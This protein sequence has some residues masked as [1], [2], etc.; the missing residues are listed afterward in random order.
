MTLSKVRTLLCIAFFALPLCTNAVTAI[1]TIDKH[2]SQ[3]WA[4]ASDYE[5]QKEADNDALEA[6]RSEARKNG[7]GKLAKQCRVA[8]RAD[9]PGYGALVCGVDGCMWG[10]GFDTA[11]DA[12][13][14]AYQGCIKSYAK[15]QDKNIGYW[16]D[17]AG[18]AKNAVPQKAPVKT[19]C[20]PRT[21]E[22]QCTSSCQNGSCIVTYRNGCQM[23]VQVQA[24]FNP[25]SNTWNYPA[26]SC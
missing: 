6:C 20:R 3:A 12:I 5:S 24:Q 25:L 9:G 19:D 17:F 7:L 16:E 21:N 1:A 2:A 18:F 14:T 22:L 10:T 4:R 8:T 11:Q 26:T 15:C 23:R 13:D